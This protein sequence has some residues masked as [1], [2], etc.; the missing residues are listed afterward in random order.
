MP[1][2]ISEW[3]GAE[4]PGLQWG[5]RLARRLPDRSLLLAWDFRLFP[6]SYRDWS[7]AY[8]GMALECWAGCFVLDSLKMPALKY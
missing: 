4:I 2:R 6:V 5:V 1:Y 7:E 8:Q 3:S